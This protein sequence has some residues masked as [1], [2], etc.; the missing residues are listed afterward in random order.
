MAWTFLACLTI[1]MIP[2]AVGPAVELPGAEGLPFLV[3]FVAGWA[4][5]SYWIAF[6]AIY[7]LDL[8]AAELRWKSLVRSGAIPLSQLESVRFRRA[9]QVVISSAGRKPLRVAARAGMAEFI[10]DLK[11]A[12]P[13]IEAEQPG[14]VY[15]QRTA[16]Q[17]PPTW[18]RI[19][20]T[21]TVASLIGALLEAGAAAGTARPTPVGVFPGG[22]TALAMLYHRG[23]SAPRIVI[24]VGAA[25]ILAALVWLAF[26][27]MHATRWVIV[28]DSVA[29]P[30]AAIGSARLLELIRPRRDPA[31]GPQAG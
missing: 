22:V 28:A 24:S 27:S 12:A 15:Q 17:A 1:V 18:S 11:Q 2:A 5:L 20:T 6:R 14:G 3:I 9:G 30:L 31:A 8:T 29:C 13:H 26:A 7:R 16:A 19:A 10:A 25:L 21:T 4:Y 23:A